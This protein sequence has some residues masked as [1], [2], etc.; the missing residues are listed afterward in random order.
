MVN[1]CLSVA[2]FSV[3]ASLAAVLLKRYA[4][5]QSL[6]VSLGACVGIMSAFMLYLSPMISEVRDIFSEAGISDSYIAIVF[7]AAAVCFITQLTCSVCRDSG[8]TAVAS[9]AEMWG[10]GA[11]A[12]MSLPIL[13]EL[14]DRIGGAIW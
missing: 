6:L 2:V 10:R 9:A 5:E 7:K 4:C 14:I 12:F 8:E 1:D 13:R 3:A 11:V